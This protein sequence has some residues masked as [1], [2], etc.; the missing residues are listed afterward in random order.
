MMDRIDGDFRLEIDFI[1]VTNDTSHK[2]KFAYEIY[3]L[4]VYSTQG[5]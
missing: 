4:P 3:Q 1:G 5:F 2:E